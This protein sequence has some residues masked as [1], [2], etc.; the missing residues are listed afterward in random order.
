MILLWGLPGEE[1]LEAVRHALRRRGAAVAFLDQR[2]VL[3]TEVELTVGATVGGRLRVGCEEIDL[4]EVTAAYVRP[5]DSR[6]MPAVERAGAE[7]VEEGHAVSVEDAM[8]SWLDIAPALVV[9]RPS[10]MASNTSKP[11]Q[12]A[13]IREH[14]FGTPDT[15]I[16]TDPEAARAF[17]AEHH[18]VIYKS[19]SGVR[20]VVAPFDP[21]DGERLRDL[22][23]CPTQFQER[24][25]GT[26]V[27]VHVVGEEL[28]ASEIASQATDYRYAAQQ[29]AT[30][31]MR[32]VE[33]PADCGDRCRA[34]AAAMELPVAG[35]DL[36]RTPA[37]D[38]TCFEV[39]PCPGFS[40]F[41]GATG[42]PI[43]DAI[44][45]LLIAGPPAQAS[46]APLAFP[47]R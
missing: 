10:A 37:G 14:G 35:I 3:E 39:N 9:N 6:R 20:S 46:A 47:S 44:A 21:G 26:D 12:A 16:T 13:I 31:A 11:Y 24:L 1:P 23:W 33:L 28:F 4:A 34:L 27:R 45:R 32:E 40:Y 38:W 8:V 22:A 2:R 18:R 25:A 30:C 43:D 41:Q 5:H 42:Q 29:G 15:L 7:S 17:H 36:R 19:I